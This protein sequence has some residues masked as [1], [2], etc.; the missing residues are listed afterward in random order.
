MADIKISSDSELFNTLSH[1][2]TLAWTKEV[3]QCCFTTLR[4]KR[5]EIG[6]KVVRHGRYVIFKFAG[7]AV[8]RDLFQK[9]LTT[10]GDLRRKFTP[11]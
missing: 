9:N 5:V 1:N 8:P 10:I 6:A 4:E 7:V 11:L 2:R 3:V